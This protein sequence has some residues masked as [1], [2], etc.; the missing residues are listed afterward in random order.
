VQLNKDLVD[1]G[2]GKDIR[3]P[4]VAP[5]IL[6]LCVFEGVRPSIQILLQT[7]ANESSLW[8]MAGASKLQGLLTR[9]LVLALKRRG[10]RSSPRFFCW[11]FFCFVLW[12]VRWC[13]RIGGLP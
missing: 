10:Y 8:Y 1:F 12:W 11:Q 3:A 4:S 13:A 7:A 5:N 2:G 9:S 6:V